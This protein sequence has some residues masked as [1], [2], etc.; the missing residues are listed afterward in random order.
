[1]NRSTFFLLGSWIM[2]F[3]CSVA[4]GQGS[5]GSQLQAHFSV[6]TSVARD[7][8]NIYTSVTT[9][10]YASIGS[11]NM[12][13]ATHRAG[14]RNVISSTGGWNYS[15]SSCPTCYFSQTNNQQI[16]GVPGVVYTFTSSGSTICSIVGTFWS[17]GGGS[18]SI[19]GCLSPSSETTTDGGF[20]G[21]SFREQ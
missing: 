20:N 8:K 6:Y 4:H 21:G 13:S 12:G 3:N 11:C 15:G 17:G 1:M 2:L 7:G 16:V 9:Q 10:G 18:S 14:A 5:C 19:P